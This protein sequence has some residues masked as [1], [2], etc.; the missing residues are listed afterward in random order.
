[1]VSP[2]KAP[3]HTST[4]PVQTSRRALRSTSRVSRGSLRVTMLCFRRG[5]RCYREPTL[6][7]W[8]HSRA[9]SSPGRRFASRTSTFDIVPSTVV[10][11]QS[12]Y[13]DSYA[14]AF[15]NAAALAAK[16]VAVNL[17]AD[18]GQ[19]QLSSS[20]TMQ[21]NGTFVFSPGQFVSGKDAK[22]NNIVQTGAG[23]IAS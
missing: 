17:P 19:L 2:R 16:A 13:E 11:T 18:A 14:N 23:G 10:R 21:L 9:I 3:G 5:M 4:A 15:F 20:G 8:S 7:A 22:G 12:Q 6:S 1:M